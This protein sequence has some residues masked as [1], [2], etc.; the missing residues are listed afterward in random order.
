MS[1]KVFG[2]R[3]PLQRVPGQAHIAHSLNLP[4]FLPNKVPKCKYLSEIC[5]L[6][7]L[8]KSAGSILSECLYNSCFGAGARRGGFFSRDAYRYFKSDA[9]YDVI[10]WHIKLLLLHLALR[11][12]STS[13][14]ATDQPLL[15]FWTFCFTSGSSNGCITRH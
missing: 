1:D 8:F 4:R 11:H 10:Y 13:P 15:T 2:K 9:F 7:S 5:C 14:K 12:V 3:I 6:K